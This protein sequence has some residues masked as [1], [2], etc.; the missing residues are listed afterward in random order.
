MG[1]GTWIYL[2]HFDFDKGKNDANK[3][4]LSN[5]SSESGKLISADAVKIGGG[6]GNIARGTSQDATVTANVKSSDTPGIK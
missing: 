5:R 3:V 6:Y 2:G 4:V 1:G